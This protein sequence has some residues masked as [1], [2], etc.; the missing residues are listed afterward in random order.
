[1]QP[2]AV[3]VMALCALEVSVRCRV[4][5]YEL[6]DWVCM[7]GTAMW[8]GRVGM[9]RMGVQANACVPMSYICKIGDITPWQCLTCDLPLRV[10]HSWAQLN[11]LTSLLCCAAPGQ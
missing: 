1:M 11:A 4:S 3:L 7:E 8:A 6:E 9:R 5:H 10:Y 2:L